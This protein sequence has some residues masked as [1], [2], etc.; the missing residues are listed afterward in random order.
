MMKNIEEREINNSELS[1]DTKTLITVITLVTVYPVGLIL[2]FAW[3]K[4]RTMIKFLI[5]LPF[6]I[7]MMVPILLVVTAGAIFLKMGEN[8]TKPETIREF[9][10]IIEVTPTEMM[11]GPAVDI[12]KK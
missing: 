12:I 9:R 1:Y 10:Q 5:L 3:M 2:M 7:G 11:R 6:I 4:W 8:L